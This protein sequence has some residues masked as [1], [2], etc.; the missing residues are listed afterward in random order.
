M[1]QFDNFPEFYDQPIRLTEEQKTK[2]LGVVQVFFQN[3]HLHEIR[4]S[5]WKM[6][7]YSLS[8]RHSVY[9]EA[10]E[11]SQLLW[12]YRELETMIEATFI[13]CQ[14][15]DWQDASGQPQTAEKGLGPK[16]RTKSMLEDEIRNL[17]IKNAEQ[18]KEL[19][20]LRYFKEHG[21][22]L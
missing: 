1:S 11:R 4:K 18:E 10:A 2:P 19:I 15:I 22:E 13:L 3:C 16:W 7:E 21:K 17:R 9:D 5:L 6:M 8:I 14:K 20:E 12:F